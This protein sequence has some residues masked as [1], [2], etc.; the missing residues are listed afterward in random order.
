MSQTT[1][2]QHAQD[3]FNAI[4]LIKLGARMQVLESLTQI[5]REK[6]LRLYRE[7]KGQSPAKG[8]L[9][10]STDWFIEPS[11]GNP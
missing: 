4:E 9:P 5:S 1:V 8:M 11:Q 6:L 2:E 3:I 10:F 7:V